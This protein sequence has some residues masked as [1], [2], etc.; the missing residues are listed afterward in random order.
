VNKK[1]K[2]KKSII[3]FSVI[4][5]M[6]LG[7]IPSV[8][9]DFV[10]IQSITPQTGNPGT[11][12]LGGTKSPTHVLVVG[13][14]EPT[15]LVQIVWDTSVSTLQCSQQN[16]VAK[17]DSTGAYTV[18]FNVPLSTQGAHTITAQNLNVS[19]HAVQSFN[20]NSV[21]ELSSTS[22]HV[23]DSVNVLGTGFAANSALAV[24]YDGTN[25]PC[26]SPL[27]VNCQSNAQGSFQ[28]SF[29]IPDSVLGRHG[30][31]AQDSSN[32]QASDVFTV[33][34]NVRITGV[35]N[36]S[37]P[38]SDLHAG[39]PVVGSV[40]QGRGTGFLSVEDVTL[41]FT[42]DRTG[43]VFGRQIDGPFLSDGKGTFTFT[44]TIPATPQLRSAPPDFSN[45]YYRA[46][47]TGCT[48]GTCPT[49]T[50]VELHPLITLNPDHAAFEQ[51]VNGMGAGFAPN[52][53]VTVILTCAPSFPSLHTGQSDPTG[54]FQFSFTILRTTQ[55]SPGFC[56]VT[57]T[58]SHGYS[59]TTRFILGTFIIPTP[60]KGIA[61]HNTGKI[62]GTDVS[63]QGF[64]F[65]KNAHVS[66]K[67]DGTTIATTTT[68]ANGD[69]TTDFVVPE[70]FG[71]TG[72]RII[73]TD[74]GTR[75]NGG[76]AA[77]SAPA[78]FTVVPWIAISASNGPVGTQV[79]ISGT[80]FG[81][82]TTLTQGTIDVRYCGA[83]GG[84]A[85]LVK[86]PFAPDK[87]AFDQGMTCS[88]IS[89]VSL[90]SPSRTLGISTAWTV[91]TT[92]SEIT[93]GTVSADSNH[94]GTFQLS[95]S[96]PESW[97]GYHPVFANE[98]N[99]LGLVQRSSFKGALFRIT[100]TVSITPSSAQS[101]KI[102]TLAGTG[103]F[104][105]EKYTTQTGDQPVQSFTESAGVVID[106][107]PFA[108]YVDQAH[109]IMNGQVDSAWAQD[110]YRPVALNARGTIIY[111]DSLF[112]V[113]GGVSGESQFLRVP[114][115]ETTNADGTAS[116][117]ITGYRFEMS[118]PTYD[119]REATTSSFT[120]SNP[121][122]PQ[123]NNHTTDSV[124]GAV[125]T[126]KDNIG[127]AM[128]AINTYTKD[129][130]GSAMSMINGHV[131]ARVGSAM[132]AINAYTKDQIGS[133]MSMINGH[134][135]SQVSSATSSVNGHTDAQITS[136]IS[137]VNSHADTA[138]STVN[139]H[140]DNQ[141]ASLSSSVS[142]LP[143]S[144]ITYVIATLAGIAA[145]AAVASTLIVSR[146]LKVAG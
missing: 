23:T 146:R 8:K 17:A 77:C 39:F 95:F 72:D 109:F 49:S 30:V 78:S 26:T 145:L 138:T 46:N 75:C 22:G 42:S 16:C 38:R 85:T 52:A 29:G 4:A 86:V 91:T 7:V 2:T 11:N 76:T 27:G 82:V 18:D 34:R 43:T 120:L 96:A 121:E 140:T 70:A 117:T 44:D 14:A 28:G 45:Y 21:I 124:N 67:F 50:A 19:V 41:S 134:V 80:G 71:G 84:Q 81:S 64:V 137:S 94:P 66:I 48:G 104:Q 60:D 130:V 132:T 63:L 88:T 68:D 123:I 135:D 92:G 112:K 58:D 103:F 31:T 25:V 5:I 113:P 99:S 108:R 55:L 15:D 54:S 12:A 3:A 90:T 125:G 53:P 13:Q 24:L 119:T 87:I 89:V 111:W 118:N 56:P 97:G 131:D 73:A 32:N 33:S 79:A 35:T 101:G 102:V 74:D 61:T 105:W 65:S 59:D 62:Q 129:Q 69:F 37:L 57:A 110:L 40:I 122:V 20:V 127:F 141:V 106:F 83:N 100:P 143:Q 116:M 126:I 133:A 115:S 114:S 98:L 1:L 93:L 136:A 6:I 9:A 128:T 107:G 47:D 36:P 144:S 10:S 139:S 51:Q 142:S